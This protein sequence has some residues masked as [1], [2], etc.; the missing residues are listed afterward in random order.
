MMNPIEKSCFTVLLVSLVKSYQKDILSKFAFD[1]NVY[2]EDKLYFPKIY[3]F[4]NGLEIL[5]C[6][7]TYLLQ[8]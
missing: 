6:K 8:T 2:M 4:A 7:R 3:Y 1:I 5:N